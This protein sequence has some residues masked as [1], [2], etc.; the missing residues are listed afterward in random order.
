MN[1]L[2][3]LSLSILI[4]NASCGQTIEPTHNKPII[5]HLKWVTHTTP[6]PIVL[7]KSHTASTSSYNWF[8]YDQYMYVTQLPNFKPDYYVSKQ[9]YKSELTIFSYDQRTHEP[10]TT[11]EAVSTDSY[12]NLILY[13]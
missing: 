8:K 4:A 7:Q 11:Y 10:L 6:F 12:G 13:T 3:I 1:A 5:H 2:F 9:K